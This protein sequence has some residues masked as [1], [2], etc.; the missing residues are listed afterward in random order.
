MSHTIQSPSSRRS[1]ERRRHQLW[2]R[3]RVVTTPP[4][5]TSRSQLE[6]PSSWLTQ[7]IQLTR[8]Q[9]PPSPS[10]SPPPQHLPAIPIMGQG[11]SPPRMLSWRALWLRSVVRRCCSRERDSAGTARDRKIDSLL[12]EKEL[13][14]KVLM[15]LTKLCTLKGY[16]SRHVPVWQSTRGKRRDGGCTDNLE[17]TIFS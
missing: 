10:Q 5:S 2:C 3:Q 13:G 9:L 8:T 16:G 15:F 1:Q 17:T 14:G 12:G 6:L 4:Q 7:Q 11:L